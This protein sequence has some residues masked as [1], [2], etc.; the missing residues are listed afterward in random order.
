MPEI[1]LS[2]EQTRV[3]R[4]SGGAVSVRDSAG[5]IV[6]VMQNTPADDPA[7]DERVLLSLSEKREIL[8]RMSQENVRWSTTEEVLQRLR[9]RAAK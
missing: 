6:A 1:V 7:S 3:F 8:R 9:E 5:R 4:E 2:E